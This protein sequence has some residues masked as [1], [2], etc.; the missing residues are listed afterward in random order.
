MFTLPAAAQPLGNYVILVNNDLGMHCMN[1]DHSYLSVLPPY[2][3]LQAQVIRRGNAA[4]MP[5]IVTAGLS[6][7]YSFPGNTYSV[8]K[9]NFWT[10]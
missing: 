10:Y 8:G 6:L 3:N 7:E 9:T 1:R 5:S 4:T 2:N